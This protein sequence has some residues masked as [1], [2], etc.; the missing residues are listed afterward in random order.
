MMLLCSIIAPPASTLSFSCCSLTAQREKTKLGQEEMN[1]N[2]LDRERPILKILSIFIWWYQL[3]CTSKPS[4]LKMMIKGAM[5]SSSSQFGCTP[6]FS[7][8]PIWCRPGLQDILL[9]K[10]HHHPFLLLPV[11][12]SPACNESPYLSH[13][14]VR[15]IWFHDHRSYIMRT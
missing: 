2:H 4:W 8:G 7:S 1:P 14:I 15:C 11:H 6:T 10:F 5:V 12:N 9:K 13:V 3:A